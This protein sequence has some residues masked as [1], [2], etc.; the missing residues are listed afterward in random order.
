MAGFMIEQDCCSGLT[1]HNT[2]VCEGGGKSKI[3][4]CWVAQW[5]F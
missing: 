3:L 5:L 1:G 4:I 2:C